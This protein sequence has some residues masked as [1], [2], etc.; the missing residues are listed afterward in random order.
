MFGSL[1]HVSDQKPLFL[2]SATAC[3]LTPRWIDQSEARKKKTNENRAQALHVVRTQRTSHTAARRKTG[4][5]FGFPI[6]A[7][8]AERRKTHERREENKSTEKTPHG[9]RGAAAGACAQASLP[10]TTT[11]ASERAADLPYLMEWM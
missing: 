4:R 3:E 1:R 2:R 5:P 7:S 10:S 6:L 11:S 8:K 9:H